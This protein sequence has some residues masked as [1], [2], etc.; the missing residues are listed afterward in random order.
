MWNYFG[1]V[2]VYIIPGIKPKKVNQQDLDPITWVAFVQRVGNIR[3]LVTHGLLFRL[4][5]NQSIVTE[6]SAWSSGKRD[7]WWHRSSKRWKLIHFTSVSWLAKTTWILKTRVMWKYAFNISVIFRLCLV[8][9]HC[10][11]K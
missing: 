4:T 1:R 6:E 10:L 7:G 3:E 2:Y 9:I 8:L 5:Y 11:W